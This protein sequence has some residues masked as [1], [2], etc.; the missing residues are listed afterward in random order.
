MGVPDV[1][2]HRDRGVRILAVLFLLFLAVYAAGAWQYDRVRPHRPKKIHLLVYGDGVFYYSFTRSILFDRDLD[3][4]NE[5][6][7]YWH[8]EKAVEAWRGHDGRLKNYCPIGSSLLWMPFVVLMHLLIWGNGFSFPYP[9]A[10]AFGSSL[11][12]WSAIVMIYRTFK[13]LAAVVA[14]WFG[15]N[16]AYYM[17]IE[18]LTSHAC[19]FFIVT[20]F[21]LQTYKSKNWVWLG[22]VY[23]VAILVRPEHAILG[24]LIARRGVWPGILI[25][26]A[27]FVPQALVWKHLTGNFV[28]PVAGSANI[29]PIHVHQVLFSTRHG[30]FLW[31][32]IYL[33]A[34]VGMLFIPNRSWKTVT[35]VAVGVAALFYGTRYAWWGFH[36][37]GSRYFVGLGV[38]FA[39]GLSALSGW[40]RVRLRREWPIW[41]VVGIFGLWNL[42]LAILYLSQTISQHEAVPL[43]D[44]ILAPLKASRLLLSR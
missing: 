11:L 20:L 38:F 22:V 42:S 16:L 41:A 14:L 3:T 39:A 40:M 21:V 35:L 34:V 26:M 25:G 28:S 37:Y 44:L 10:A 6:A 36:S 29:L 31:H 24:L 18:P 7:Y 5:A 17:S 12:A 27:L 2:L 32:P 33:L 19:S 43:A 8:E 23:G 15:T 13:D 1:A 4:T 9:A 30:L